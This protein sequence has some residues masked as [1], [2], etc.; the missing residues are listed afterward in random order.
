MS[1]Q[2]RA[3]FDT[4]LDYIPILLTIIVA[5]IAGLFREVFGIDNDTMLQLALIAVLGLSVNLLLEKFR[6]QRSMLHRL[7]HIDTQITS[8]SSGNIRT[9]DGRLNMREAGREAQTFDIVAWAGMRLFV[10]NEDFFEQLIKRGCRIR[11]I[12]LDKNSGA[13]E[14]VRQGA[15]YA[16]LTADIEETER[17]AKQFIQALGKV[18]G[19]L[20]VRASTWLMPMGL[21]MIDQQRPTGVISIGFHP[22]DPNSSESKQRYLTVRAAD[23]ALHF[24]YFAGQFDAL[25]Q[26]SAV[27]VV[28]RTP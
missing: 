12:I 22:L 25:W 19:S 24:A 6:V 11:M 9:A 4:L 27:N 28:A 8:L 2:L 15:N 16:R 18:R 26:Q 20:E 17:R 1:R 3:L 21:I 23:D 5:T 14:V 10:D 13:A 7:E